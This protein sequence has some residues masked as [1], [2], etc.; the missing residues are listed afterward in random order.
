MVEP[1]P[2]DENGGRKPGSPRKR[3][4]LRRLLEGFLFAA[5]AYLLLAYVLLPY[6]WRH[7]EHLPA[8]ASAPKTTRTKQGIPGD[9]INLGAVGSEEE[10]LRSFAAAGWF[11]A[12]PITLRSSVKIA[13]SVVLRRE[14]ETAPVSSLYLFGRKQDLAFEKPVGENASRRHHVRF[15]KADGYDLK[16]R[17]IWLG[18]GTYDKSVGLS[19]RTAQITHHIDADVDAERDGIV[20]DLSKAGWVERIFQITGVGPTMTG[21]N[22]GGDWYYTDGEVSVVELKPPAQGASPESLE[23]PPIVQLKQQLW[24]LIKPLLKSAATT[25]PDAASDAQPET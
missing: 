4:L 10:I 25:P 9:P 1:G 22:G 11:P 23:N 6:L 3:R 2:S 12:D 18:A 19:R 20:A 24:S 7:Y 16:G 13:D 5:A 14:Y 21:R 15:W 8:L 17:P